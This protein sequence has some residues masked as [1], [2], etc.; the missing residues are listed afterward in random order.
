MKDTAKGLIDKA[1]ITRH[2]AL[3][4]LPQ[5]LA[6]PSQKG[7]LRRPI[8]KAVMIIPRR[9][10]PQLLG[11]SRTEA[12]RF[13]MLVL[14]MFH[15]ASTPLELSPRATR[16][17]NKFPACVCIARIAAVTSSQSSLRSSA[18]TSTSP[19]FCGS[20]CC[21]IEAGRFLTEDT[22]EDPARRSR[23]QT[24]KI[25]EVWIFRNNTKTERLFRAVV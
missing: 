2:V 23:N 17:G 11:P 16:T 14:Q 13:R 12:L 1:A 18:P 3:D 20:W 8:M 4:G 5:K 7:R 25:V 6:G 9:H 21:R 19:S 24:S 10:D 15:Q 22:E